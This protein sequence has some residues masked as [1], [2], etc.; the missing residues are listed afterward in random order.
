MS[1]LLR[2]AYRL[3]IRNKFIRWTWL[4][5]LVL[6][7]VKITTDRGLA[8][9]KTPSSKTI[10]TVQPSDIE[11]FTIQNQG[12]EDLTFS[13]QDTVWIAVKNNIMVRLSDDSVSIYLDLFSKIER[14]AVKTLS[15]TEGVAESPK[16][17]VSIFNKNGAKH[18]L[19]IYYTALDSLS[20]E[21][22]TFVK[23]EN[24]RLLHG[25]RGDWQM[26]LSKNFDDFRDRRL[27]NFS[28]REASEMSFQNPTDT[29][30]VFRK[31]TTWRSPYN[32]LFNPVLFKNHVENL[33]ILRGSIFYDEDRDLLVDRKMSNRLIIKTPTDTAIITAFRLDNY[34]VVHSTCN[35]DN[36]FKME[37]TEGIFFR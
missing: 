6:Y 17:Q 12:D 18:S 32:R 20:N 2:W 3:L 13:R 37:A 7:G 8:W 10:F 31:D 35:P 21:N 25:V 9:K 23:L 33:N 15:N 4:L 26:V 30:N 28:I 1:Q 19:S 14:L 16:W 11:S 5:A 24:E 27:L 34:F 36:Y 29:L 22:L